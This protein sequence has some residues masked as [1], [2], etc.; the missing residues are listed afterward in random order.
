MVYAINI[1]NDHQ[2]GGLIHQQF[3][4]RHQSFI[5]RQQYDVPTYDGM[6]YDKYDTPATNYLVWVDDEGRVRGVSRK[7]PTDRA[8]MIKEIWPAIVTEIPLP[9][10]AS[11]WESSRFAVDKTLD[12]A[13]RRQI[14]GDLVCAGLEFGLQNN[15]QAYV[16]VM[17][18]AIWRSVFERCGWPIEKIGP[19]IALDSGERIVAGWMAV[20]EEYL[21]QVKKT[22]SIHGSSLQNSCVVRAVG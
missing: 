11:I 2:Y 12:I 22:M 14:V 1:K 8:Y 18:P 3:V 10:S 4:L 7:A 17:P 15:I 9:S 19:V 13:T 21:E 20:K 16:G 6:E 5:E